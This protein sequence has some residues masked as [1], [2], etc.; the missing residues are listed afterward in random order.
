MSPISKF[1]LALIC[2]LSSGMVSAQPTPTGPIDGKLWDISLN[3]HT[4]LPMA[5]IPHGSFLMG[6]PDDEKGRKVS[7]GPQTHVTLTKSY[8]MG[9]TEVTIAQWKAVT[10]ENL[11]DKVLR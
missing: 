1:I 7:E 9:K 5:W 8:W 11:R 10:G 3:G 4:L 2:C 6:S